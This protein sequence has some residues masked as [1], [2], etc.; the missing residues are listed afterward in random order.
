MSRPRGAEG[1][2]AAAHDDRVDSTHDLLELARAGDQAALETLFARYTSPLKR[3]ARGRLPRWARD[4]GD[5][6]DLVQETVLQTLKQI[7]RFEPRRD[8]SF[9][10]YLR[11]ALHNRLLNEIRRVNRRPTQALEVDV[12]DPA[13]S[14][15]EEVIGGQTLASYEAGLARLSIDERDAL[16]ARIELGQS[17]AE[18]A[19]SLG[20]PTPD[21]A[22]MAVS[23]A[24]LRLAQEMQRER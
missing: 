14:P 1:P 3:W 23:R 7:G 21:A 9:H 13:P 22:R 2:P 4:L 19:R 20:K 15:V 8:G 5:T 10:A 6:D 16:V 18:I 12:V 11:T 17:Y 24:L